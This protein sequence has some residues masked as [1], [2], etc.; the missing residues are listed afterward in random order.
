M[1]ECLPLA[2]V[3]IP[4]SWDRVPHW[5]SSREPASPSAYVSASLCGIHEEINKILKK[6]CFSDI[7]T[8]QYLKNP[9]TRLS[10]P[11]IKYTLQRDIHSVSNH[12]RVTGPSLI[13]P[14]PPPVTRKTKY[15]AMSFRHW[16]TGAK[17]CNP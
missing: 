3:V 6:K 10:A 12:D 5:A 2:Q 8:P 13:L 11:P 14:T 4:G 7:Y 17:G 9:I 15:K 16:T 1:D